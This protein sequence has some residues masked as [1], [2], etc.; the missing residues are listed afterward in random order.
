MSI[1]IGGSVI[2]RYSRVIDGITC[3]E[4]RL[5]QNN[6][7]PFA[8][9]DI[10]YCLKNNIFVILNIDTYLTG[11]RWKPSNQELRNFILDTKSR[12]KSLGAN[13]KNLRFTT[14]NESDEY[15][16]FNYYMNMVRVIHDALAKD[17]DL[18]AGNFRTSSKD[19]YEN[20]A[21]QY[22]TGCFE[23]L[24]FHFQDTL[25]EADDIFLF[26]NWILYLKNKYQ[27]KRLAVTEGNN[28]YNVS[29]LKGHNLLKYQIS[30]AERIGC[31]DFC[32]PYVNFMSNSEESADYMSYNIDNSPVS[33][34]WQDMKEFI[35]NKKPK[36]LIDMIELNLVKP[37]SKNEETRAIQQIMIDE[38]YDL[39]PYG[40]DGIYGKITEQAIKK[41]QSDNNL[42][43][44]GIVGKE[45]WQW[46][47]SNLPTGIA[48]FT[49][50]LVRKAV[51][52]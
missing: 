18:G 46:I 12:L 26:A 24:D 25:D 28:F 41:W 35:N 9:K 39:S 19:W 29:T 6:E 13:K 23:V 31:E 8:W 42:T 17:F 16:D 40:A 32:F 1:R 14:D 34:Y 11:S 33:P 51:F 36:E 43:I 50:L 3:A 47:I 22:S 2:G 10:E 15:C 52:K 49:Q 21:R 7:H 20:L 38:G 48:R 5:L 4:I 45:T 37:G 30:E 27:F 44:D